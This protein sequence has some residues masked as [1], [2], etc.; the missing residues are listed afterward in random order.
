MRRQVRAPLLVAAVLLSGTGGAQAWGQEPT[1]EIVIDDPRI[2]EASGLAVS[3]TDPELLYTINDSGNEPVIYVVDRRSGAVVGTTAL[4][5]PDPEDHDIEALSV[6][7]RGDLW[8]ADTGDNSN[9]RTDVALYRLPAPGPGSTTVTPQRYPLTYA[10][11]SPDVEALLIDPTTGRSWLVTKGFFGGQV[12][13]L[14]SQPTPGAVITPA[15]VAGVRI[16]GVVTDATVLPTG[17]AAVLRTYAEAR[18]Y[19]LPSWDLVGSFR[20]PRQE[21]GESVAA[22]PSGETLLAGS[23][24]SP[25]LIDVVPVPQRVLDALSS[26]QSGPTETATPEPE[27]EPA[28]ADAASADDSGPLREQL[29]WVI[30]GGA[31]LLVVAVALLLVRARRSRTGG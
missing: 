8:I 30:V 27:A 13:R 29:T 10:A 5:G 19:R 18:V 7:G 15:P 14:P 31:A 22:L 11:D 4:V 17:A 6:D 2:T 12:L 9:E 20:L 21:Q 3:P 23:E 28:P 16:Q 26:E 24:G 1:T 25:A